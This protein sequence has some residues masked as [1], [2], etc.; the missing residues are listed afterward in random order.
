M[1]TPARSAQRPPRPAISNG[2]AK[3]SVAPEV[4]GDEISEKP[5]ANST[6]ERMRSKPATKIAILAGLDTNGFTLRL[7]VVSGVGVGVVDVL[8]TLPP[9][10]QELRYLLFRPPAVVALDLFEQRLRRR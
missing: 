10:Q 1:I 5:V 9:L 6:T 8:I 4:P 7:R 3:R 2:I